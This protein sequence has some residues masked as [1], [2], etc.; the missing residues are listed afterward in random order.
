MAKDKE[1]KIHLKTTGD[2]SGAKQVTDAIDDATES[3]E[4]FTSGGTTSLEKDF[5]QAGKAADEF[6]DTVKETAE[7]TKEV[8]KALDDATESLDSFTSGGTTTLEKDFRKAE[9]AADGLADKVEEVADGVKD[10]SKAPPLPFQPAEVQPVAK[11]IAELTAEVQ[12]LE[13]E[14]ESVPV[15]GEAFI[16]LGGKVRAARKDLADA[17]QQSRKLVGSMGR[18]GDAGMAVLE[19]SRAFEDAQYGIRGVLNNIPGLIAMLGGG[20]GLAGVIS[21]A[22]VAGTQL[23]EAFSDSKDAE[24]G[25]DAMAEAAEKFAARMKKLRDRQ[26]EIAAL[27]TTDLDASLT[28]E[29]TALKLQTAAFLA[30]VQ[31]VRDRIAAAEALEGVLNVGALANVDRDEQGGKITT[32]E[33][34]RRR[35]AI[36]KSARER[37]LARANE[38]SKLDEEVAVEAR[39]AARRELEAAKARKEAADLSLREKE[40]ELE[41]LK[42]EMA[43][44]GQINAALAQIED[45]ERTLDERNVPEEFR[46]AAGAEKTRE[47]AASNFG[48]IAESLTRSAEAIEALVSARE[49]LGVAEG[50][51]PL[52]RAREPIAKETEAAVESIAKHQAAAAEA[53]EKITE[54]NASLQLAAQAAEA[55]KDR[56][57]AQRDALATQ[58]SAERRN[59]LVAQRDDAEKKFGDQ[60]GQLL[61]GILSSLGGAAQAPDVQQKATAIRA[62]LADGLQR[63]ETGDAQILLQ[64]LVSRMDTDVKLRISIN[65]KV[66]T[67][68]GAAESVLRAHDTRLSDLESAFSNLSQQQ[69]YPNN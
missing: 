45:A 47:M 64:R 5:R 51:G 7:A 32:E 61:D 17:H 42:R 56:Q 58:A 26:K 41:R 67:T 59:E 22:A 3:F 8:E 4:T 63:A 50:V 28:E 34:D 30:N 43:R 13:R 60:V 46:S 57:E 38:L 2:P 36:E 68:L 14:L 25:L 55:T 21:L 49:A 11:S 40:I 6:K 19:F 37:Q 54:A 44:R 16:A 1:F 69:P 62:L 15:G 53:A 52:P 18:G 65:Q 20:A 66:E 39:E 9:E 24:E 23:W 31:A 35:A 27:P 48:K 33:A 12:R 29:T 10:F